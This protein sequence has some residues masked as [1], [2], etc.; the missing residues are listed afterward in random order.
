MPTTKSNS[1][2]QGKTEQYQESLNA[3]FYQ[4]MLNSIEDYAVFT[5]DK[6]G[7]INS[8]NYGAQN[9][10]G[11]TPDEIIGQY[12]GV[13]F[14]D[15]D[16]KENADK[17]ELKEALKTRRGVDERYHVRKNKSRF[18]SSGLVFPI[19]DAA[20]KHT[21]FTKVMRN[22]DERRMAEEQAR[23]SKNYAES[24]VET[25]R[26]PML[27]LN[28]DFSVNTANKA[29]YNLFNIKRKV[30]SAKPFYELFQGQLDFTQIKLLLDKIADEEKAV[31]DYEIIQEFKNIGKRIFLLN[32]RKIYDPTSRTDLLLLSIE[33]VT[34]KRSAE[35][36]KDD[37]ISIAGH[38]IKTPITVIKAQAQMLQKRSQ[39]FGDEPFTQSLGKIDEKTD[40]LIALINYLLDITQIETGE[41][42]LVK[43]DFDLDKLVAESVEEMRIVDTKHKFELKGKCTDTVFADRFRIAQ[44]LNNL[45]N[46]AAKYSPPDSQINI[47][48]IKSSNKGHITISVQDF[49]MGVPEEEQGKLF[50]RFSRSSNVKNLN[51]GGLGLGLHISKEIVNQHNG[52]IW[53]KSEAGKGSTFYFRIPVKM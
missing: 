50:R 51:I 1:Y 27:V 41:M 42:Q 33:D 22:V 48:L 32:G 4:D 45:L 5:I 3:G 38:E 12:F 21:G 40:K 13:L 8:W 7:Y 49:G 16:L 14:T 34:E 10:L 36:Q 39:K 2:V 25:A 6:A 23:G 47:K 37:F 30:S 53:F 28:K 31:K 18:F 15:E 46:N 9:L 11:Y 24:I 26:E 17:K 35:Q 29:F 52:K 43:T 20:Q 19:Y 44:V